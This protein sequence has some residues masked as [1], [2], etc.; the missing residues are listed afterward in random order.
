MVSTVRLQVLKEFPLVRDS[1]PRTPVPPEQE[2][3]GNHWAKWQ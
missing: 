3:R 2:I 1:N